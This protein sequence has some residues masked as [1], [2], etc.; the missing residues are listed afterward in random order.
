MYS[1]EN[2]KIRK[3]RIRKDRKYKLVRKTFAITGA[4]IVLATSGAAFLM[5]S[6][7]LEPA[8][9]TIISNYY[10]EDSKEYDIVSYIN[11]SKELE[12]LNLEKYEI[13]PNLYEKYNIS[14]QLKNPEEI[15]KLISNIKFMNAFVSSK[16]ITKQSPI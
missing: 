11:L 9:Q 4:V 12:K 16:N 6:G 3:K 7:A 2:Q 10:G 5:K 15:N 8:P 14:S 13:T 1:Y